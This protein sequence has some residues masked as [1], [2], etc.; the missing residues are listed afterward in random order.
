MMIHDQVFAQAMA[1]AGHLEQHQTALL[2]VLCRSSCASL[3]AMLKQGLE[4]EDCLADFVSAAS[5]LALAALSDAGET[6][7]LEQFSAGDLTIRKKH[8]GTAAACL[9]NQARVLMAPYVKESFF[10]LGV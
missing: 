10:F 8:S 7:D 9:R 1:L 6:E 5:L 2:L 4:P 3:A